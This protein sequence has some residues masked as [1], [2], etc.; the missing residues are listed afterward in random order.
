[1]WY[2]PAYGFAQ[3]ASE[4]FRITSAGV[5]Q[6][7]EPDMA[8]AMEERPSPAATNEISDNDYPSLWTLK[9]TQSAYS[10]ILAYFRS[11]Q[12]EAAGIL[13]GPGRDDPV[14]THFEPDEDGDG[15]SV[16]FHINAP[17]L[18]RIL[19]RVKPAGLDCK[20]I[21]HSHPPGHVRPS[22]GDLA[23]VR[24]LLGKPANAAAHQCFLPIF[25]Q[26]R[27]H[28]YIFAH[29]RLWLAELILI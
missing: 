15:T 14:V 3:P 22:A 7:N 11:R 18:N 16:S 26:G 20:G 17:G 6:P 12:P 27:F 24:R 28:P 8:P 2:S 5:E 13:L 23:Y 4:D 25:C 10:D 21:I 9:I 29:D 1:M 19:Q